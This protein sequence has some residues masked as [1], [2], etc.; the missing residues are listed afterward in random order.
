MAEAAPVHLS[1]QEFFQ[2]VWPSAGH[3]ALFSGK[4]HVWVDGPAEAAKQAELMASGGRDVYFSVAAFSKKSRAARFAVSHKLLVVDFDVGDKPSEYATREDALDAAWMWVR[5]NKFHE[6]TFII[7]SGNG[8]YFMWVLTGA[9]ASDRWKAVADKFK[10]AMQATGLMFDS[11]VPA[12]ASRIIRVPGTTNHKDPA[13]PR[14]CVII[15]DSGQA[16]SL[17]DFERALPLTGPRDLASPL[18]PP[19]KT[20]VQNDYTAGLDEDYPPADIRLIIPKCNQIAQGVRDEG[21]AT[22]PLWRARLSVVWR[23]VDGETLIHG[24]SRGD[25][26]YDAAQTVAKAEGTQGPAT[27]RHFEELNPE[28]CRGCPFS[29]KISSPILLGTDLPEP[30][31]LPDDDPEEPRINQFG[32]WRVTEKGVR[33]VSRDE[34][35]GTE[36]LVPVSRCPI[37]VT[38]VRERAREPDEN[39][40]SS[41]QIRWHT[42]EGR[43]KTAVA[44]QSE[45]HDQK[46]MT[47][48]LADQNLISMVDN[49]K[50]LMAYIKEAT[51]EI[52]KLDRTTT[53]YDRWGWFD[54]LSAFVMVGHRVTAEGVEPV[55]IQST[56]T[57][58]VQE[59]PEGGSA[60]A[61]GEAVAKLA[62]NSKCHWHLFTIMAGFGSPL[63]EIMGWQCA[64]LSLAGATGTGKTTAM[65]GALSI[66]G[67]PNRM[68]MSSTATANAVGLQTAA[69]KNVPTGTDETSRWPPWRLCDFI[70]DGTNGEGKATLTQQRAMRRPP[71]WSLLP[72]ITTNRAVYDYPNGAVDEPIRRRVLELQFSK[73]ETIPAAVAEELHAS[74]DANYGYAG[75]E[76]MQ[77]VIRNKA[78]VK[79]LLHET[80]AAIKASGQLDDAD[81][82][83]RWLLVTTFVGTS[84]ARE[85]GIFPEGFDP[86][87]AFERVAQ[88]AAQVSRQAVPEEVQIKEAVAEFLVEHSDQIVYW[89][90]AGAGHLPGERTKFVDTD[91]DTPVARYDWVTDNLYVHASELR[92]YLRDEKRLTLSNVQEWVRASGIEQKN[93]KIARRTPSVPCIVFP[94]GR[95]GLIMDEVVEGDGDEATLKPIE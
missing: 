70:Y 4:Q 5:T 82:F 47:T 92:R 31:V 84:L 38:E 10:R 27:C 35:A 67:N 73:L 20:K 57:I 93:F 68:V 37:W 40:N 48:W 36:D 34:D 3:F 32:N 78:R 13:N 89:A 95:I 74:L 69:H 66:Y 90:S 51:W 86:H 11:V 65:Q 87:V 63:L 76:Y 26:R 19:S 80:D 56:T 77:H 58:G 2:R 49:V 6:P 14:P 41:L 12:D 45:I 16:V 54:D 81:R 91:V 53:Y 25:P 9:V 1:I 8:I 46:S 94:A 60:K 17:E 33:L 79:K 71:R 28:G 43:S 23:C 39:D 50:A 59:L 7:S 42:P 55:R 44:M 61:W 30:K 72:I 88:Y 22:E 75:L 18:P 21:R 29:G 15:H 62:D 83:Q 24:F 64:V 52:T 85:A